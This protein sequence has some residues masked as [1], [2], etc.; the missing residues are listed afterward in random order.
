MTSTPRRK[1]HY[2]T[3]RHSPP[4]S[5]GGGIR[6]L[7]VLH[8][9]NLNF[10]LRTDIMA[11]SP[12][13]AKKTAGLFVDVP[14]VNP[15]SA[16]VSLSGAWCR[17]RVKS[18]RANPLLMRRATRGSRDIPGDRV[19]QRVTRQSLRPREERSQGPSRTNSRDPL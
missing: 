13:V 5:A 10:H 9:A 4:A 1:S 18:A 7:P 3:G 15:R 8:H 12:L 6:S 11:E 19:D 14:S 2:E 16:T 17:G